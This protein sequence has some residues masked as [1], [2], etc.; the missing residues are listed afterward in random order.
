MIGKKKKG[1][2]EKKEEEE[3]DKKQKQK[4]IKQKLLPRYTLNITQS[5]LHRCI[6]MMKSDNFM[7]NGE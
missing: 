1:K 2:R 5:Y 3:D 7:G 4:R 6:A